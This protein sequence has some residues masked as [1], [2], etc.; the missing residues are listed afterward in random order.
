MA[1]I[2]TWIREYRTKQ[3]LELDDFARAVN[4]YGRKMNPPL[5]CTITDTLMHMLEIG[6]VTHPMIANAIAEYCE[7]T[8]EQRDMIVAEIHRGKWE[9]HQKVE[10]AKSTVSWFNNSPCGAKPV[11]KV[12]LHGNVIAAYES[13]VDAARHEDMNADNI[14]RRCKRRRKQEIT[15]SEPYTFRYQSEWVQMSKKEQLRDILAS[16]GEIVG[17]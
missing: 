3:G 9:P 5:T 6:A 2:A 11:V 1:V 7:A 14:R 8:P 4:R 15:L 10:Y 13:V 17:V 16:T 12:D